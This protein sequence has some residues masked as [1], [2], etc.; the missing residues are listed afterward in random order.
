M[1]ALRP[2][3]ELDTPADVLA[4]NEEFEDVASIGEDEQVTDVETGEVSTREESFID[5]SE[6]DPFSDGNF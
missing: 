1:S 2:L 5:F 6:I 3:E 4:Q